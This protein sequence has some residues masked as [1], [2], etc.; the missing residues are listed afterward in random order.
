MPRD[1]DGD[2]Y[3][4]CPKTWEMYWEQPHNTVMCEICEQDFAVAR[5]LNGHNVQFLYSFGHCTEMV[6]CPRLFL[7][8]MNVDLQKYCGNCFNKKVNEMIMEDGLTPS[9]IFFKPFKGNKVGAINTAFTY[10]KDENYKHYLMVNDPNIQAQLLKKQAGKKVLQ[11]KKRKAKVITAQPCPNCPVPDHPMITQGGQQVGAGV[12]GGS[13]L[14][15]MAG[16]RVAILHCF[17]CQDLFC[18]ECFY[19]T[20]ARPPWTGRLYI[21][22]IQNANRI[23]F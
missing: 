1:T 6:R 8:R 18:N 21:N 17:A 16:V 3:F 9:E 22:D 19:R 7:C 13:K 12:G 14:N 23:F 15:P 4:Y 10:I 5:Y 2:M 20:H 11:E